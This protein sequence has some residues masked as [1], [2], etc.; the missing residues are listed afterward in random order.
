MPLSRCPPPLPDIFPWLP[1]YYDL[2]V[3]TLIMISYHF[4]VRVTNTVIIIV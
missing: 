3:K 2:N 4:M 1:A